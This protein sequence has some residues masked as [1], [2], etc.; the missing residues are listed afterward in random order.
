MLFHKQTSSSKSGS[1]RGWNP[2]LDAHEDD[3]KHIGYTFNI[4]RW[5]RRKTSNQI[6]KNLPNTNQLPIINDKNHQEKSRLTTSFLETMS[7]TIR[8]KN[9]TH[10]KKTLKKVRTRWRRD[11]AKNEKKKQSWAVTGGDG[12]GSVVLNPFKWKSSVIQNF[13]NKTKIKKR[14]TIS[15]GN[16]LLKYFID[17]LTGKG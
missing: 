6:F 14:I 12:V 5:W 15:F 10:K 11:R 17:K 4:Q 16:Y 1:D 7:L 8:A 9:A 3:C 2:R 13:W